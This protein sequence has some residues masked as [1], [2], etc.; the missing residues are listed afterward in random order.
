MDK[1][2]Y[3][4]IGLCAGNDAMIG[5]AIS[6]NNKNVVDLITKHLDDV[7][8]DDTDIDYINV[9]HEDNDDILGIQY[10]EFRVA[11][12]VMRDA[13]LEMGISPANLKNNNCQLSPTTSQ[14]LIEILGI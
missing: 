2:Y 3:Y 8:I 1:R 6:D 9:A 12:R 11:K 13:L 4:E 7:G 14:K 10:D 5:Y